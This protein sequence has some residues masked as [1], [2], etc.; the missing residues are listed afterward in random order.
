MEEPRVAPTLECV[1]VAAHV[2]T[3]AARDT[4]QFRRSF[5]TLSLSTQI[6][7]RSKILK[8]GHLSD[9][10]I[11]GEKPTFCDQASREY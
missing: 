7:V 5:V 3:S 10:P 11:S 4:T 9:R 8:N 2:V 6:R 1:S